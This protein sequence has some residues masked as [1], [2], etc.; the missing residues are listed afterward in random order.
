[1]PTAGGILRANYKETRSQT[2]SRVESQRDGTDLKVKT[3]TTKTGQRTD[4]RLIAQGP[5]GWITGINT[6]VSVIR[7][8]PVCT[9]RWWSMLL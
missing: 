8:L 4:R 9:K 7:R 2:G 5:M 3:P 6:V 1:M